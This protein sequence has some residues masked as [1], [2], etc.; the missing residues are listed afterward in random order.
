MLPALP[1]SA[2][3]WSQGLLR[4]PRSGVGN[5]NS[6]R[7]STLARWRT[8]LAPRPPPRPGD[9]AAHASPSSAPSPAAPRP[10]SCSPPP[11]RGPGLFSTGGVVRAP[12][13]YVH[14]AP[15]AH[16][17][18]PAIAVSGRVLPPTRSPAGAAAAADT[19]RP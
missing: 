19:S 17:P 11:Q 2:A 1:M 4:A 5:H 10:P 18:L 7:R 9:C 12:G 6:S 3:R 14:V 16:R 15:L 13:A 8:C